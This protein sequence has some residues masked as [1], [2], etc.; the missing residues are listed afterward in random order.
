MEGTGLPEYAEHL[1]NVGGDRGLVPPQ[2][3]IFS[4]P[5]YM[6]SN[7]TS[8]GTRINPRGRHGNF[9]VRIR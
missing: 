4:S 2:A 6:L 3:G 1:T 5:V 7:S 9:C 8:R